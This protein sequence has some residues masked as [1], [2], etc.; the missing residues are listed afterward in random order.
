MNLCKFQHCDDDGYEL[1]EG[2]IYEL[3]RQVLEDAIKRP[4]AVPGEFIL[5]KQQI[6][7][8]LRVTI[9]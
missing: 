8:M 7:G 4:R 9:F 5:R 6:F 2:N 1:V 3:A